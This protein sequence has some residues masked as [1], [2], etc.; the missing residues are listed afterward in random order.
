MPFQKTIKKKPLLPILI[1]FCFFFICGTARGE[2]S[3]DIKW[4]TI[5]TRHAIVRYQSMD[6]LK[7]FN[8]KIKY[9]VKGSGLMGLFS[10]SGPEEIR[11]I[12]GK[13][14]DVIFEKV[15]EIL[16]MRK[17]MKKVTIN[18]YHDED[19]LH[20]AFEQ[21]YRK[22]CR[23]R[24]WYEFKYHTVFL[25]VDDMHEGMLAHEMAHGIIDHYL[26]VRPPT[27]TAEILA[28]YVDTHLKK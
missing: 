14:V 6:D 15:Q 10:S 7:R 17:K 11:D 9:R 16:D 12:V 2:S 20:A 3:P 27:A 26:K 21:V 28:R 18:V 22:S 5:E 4:E 1:V 8:T 19:Q 25:C 23:I 24:A 13:K